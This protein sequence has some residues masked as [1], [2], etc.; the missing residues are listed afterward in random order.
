MLRIAP[1]PFLLLLAAACGGSDSHASARPEE[2]RR[3]S[4]LVEV[5]DPFTNLVWENVSVRVVESWQEWS[6]CVCKS[7]F[8]D[9]YLTDSAGRVLLDEFVLSDAQVGF[10]ED[11]IGRAVLAPYRDEDEATVWL[12]IDAVG[13][14]PVFVE[15]ELR[16][17]GP[18]VFVEVPFY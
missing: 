17:N 16:W 1:A 15:V 11:G 5:Y 6:G 4:I 10:Q 12:E 7:P 9:W 14:V 8:A 18:D 3:V 13:F 2:P